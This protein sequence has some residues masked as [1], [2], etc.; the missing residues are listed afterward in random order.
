MA[1]TV[2]AFPVPTGERIL[3]LLPRLRW[4]LDG[5]GPALLPVPA[6]DA[7]ETA[8]LTTSLAAGAALAD[9]EDDAARPDG[10]GDRHLRVP[11]ARR[12]ARCC[13]R[14]RLA[15]SIEGTRRRLST[16][17]ALADTRVVPT[18][19]RPTSDA[20]SWL[21]ALPAHHIA[22]MQVLLRSIA[23]GT[24]PI[25]L[26]T[27]PPFTAEL[28][29]AAVHRMPA[30]RR[31]TSLVPT[32]LHRVLADPD[33]TTA[34]TTFAAVLVGGAAT[35]LALI[36]DAEQAGARIVTTYGMSETCGGC[37]YDGV[38][39]DGVER[40]HRSRDG[41][42]R[43][44]GPPASGGPCRAPS[45]G[46]A[47]PDRWSPAA[48]ATCRGIRRSPR[49]PS[50]GVRTFLTEDLALIG[51]RAD[52]HRR[53]RRRRDRHRRDQDRPGGGGVGAEQG[54][55][56]GRRRGHRGAGSGMG[57]RGGRGRAGRGPVRHR[58]CRRCAGP[59]PTRT[60]RPPRRGTC[61][62]SSTFRS[63]RPGKADRAAVRE[64]AGPRTGSGTD[65]LAGN[66]S[67]R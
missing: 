8:R 1:R 46:S 37:V 66:D 13:P 49:D 27:A 50:T 3:E 35:P 36:D 33:A 10:A 57:G 4:A 16:L 18:I 6:H 52:P 60:D 11:P 61:C 38:P 29:T 59:P 17:P 34:L 12:R 40:E 67:R 22:G 41:P 5:N 19:R 44:A 65:P 64:L 53:P 14:R 26:D 21:L 42:D 47:S 2:E 25:I 56:G 31:F 43:S 28:F 62:S 63:A 23:A 24:E 48:T 7:A 9:V 20:G 30:G 54:H 39:L 45:G 55:R 32:Q 15:A 58:T 51:A